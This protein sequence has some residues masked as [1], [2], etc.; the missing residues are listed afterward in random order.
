MSIGWRAHPGH[1]AVMQE[2]SRIVVLNG[3]S[4]AGKTTL[5]N[6]FRDQ[7]AAVGDFWLLIGIDDFLA[8]LPIEWKAAGADVGAAHPTEAST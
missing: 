1:D 4:S 6:A 5:A 7:R 8:K 2:M 3:S